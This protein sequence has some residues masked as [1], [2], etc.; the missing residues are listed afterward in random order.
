M[1]ERKKLS[2]NKPEQAESDSSSNN[3]GI[4]SPRRKPPVRGPGP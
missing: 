2:L 3:G 1:T 4:D